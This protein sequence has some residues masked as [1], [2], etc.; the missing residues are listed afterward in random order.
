MILITLCSART[1]SH[2]IQHFTLFASFYHVNSARRYLQFPV[3]SFCN[4]NT[5]N[6]YTYVIYLF[7]SFSRNLTRYKSADQHKQNK[8]PLRVTL[9]SVRCATIIPY[10]NNCKICSFNKAG[11]DFFITVM[12]PTS[13]CINNVTCIFIYS[14]FSA[15][16]SSII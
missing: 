7:I 15:R 13:A 10:Y 1:Y 4:T 6:T 16:H 9:S 5:P 12:A 2:K 14:F 8:N 3:S 11:M